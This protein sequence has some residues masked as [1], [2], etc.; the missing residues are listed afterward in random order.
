[1]I[2]FETALQKVL[3]QV[4]NYGT[5]KIHLSESENRV[6]GESV[7]ADRDFPPFD[8]ATKDGIAINSK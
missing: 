5:E 3:E 8:R 2:S 1:M 4:Q 6:L 7:Y